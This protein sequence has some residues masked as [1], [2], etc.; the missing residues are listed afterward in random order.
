MAN[1]KIRSKSHI[2]GDR[3]ISMIKDSILPPE[4][5]V[6]DMNP[7]YGID[8]DVELFD[9]EDDK[10]VTLGEHIFIQA[11]G[12]E[13]PKYGKHLFHSSTIDAIKFVMKTSELNLV[14]RMGSALPVLL[15]L[16]DL[17]DNKAFQ[18][19]LNDYISKVLPVQNPNYRKQGDVTI[20]IPLKK[21]AFKYGSECI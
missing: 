9:Y 13:D 14:E 11:K 10:C 15:V 7:D 21:S 5:V 3:A 2:T 19:C 8:L 20:Y 17:I 16:V 6:R 4:W 18:I 12:T 1:G